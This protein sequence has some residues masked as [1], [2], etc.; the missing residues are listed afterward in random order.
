MEKKLFGF[1]KTNCNLNRS[2]IGTRTWN[3]NFWENV[4]H[5]DATD[6]QDDV[7]ETYCMCSYYTGN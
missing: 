7:I 5:I 6:F 1:L 4:G 3:S 2:N